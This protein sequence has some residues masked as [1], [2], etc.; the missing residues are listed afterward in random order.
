MIKKIHFRHLLYFAFRR[1]Q[2][3]A[4]SAREICNVYGVDAI[5]PRTAQD[6]FTKF[7]NGNFNLDDTPRSGRPTDFDEDRL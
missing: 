2:K 4:E 3:A 7:K 1:C 5:A 6:W